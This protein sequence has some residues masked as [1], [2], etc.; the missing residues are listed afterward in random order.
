MQ[1]YD[2]LMNTVTLYRAPTTA[3]DVDAVGDWLDDRIDATV[4]VRDRF[5]ALYGDESLAETFASARVLDPYDRETGNTMLGIVR[6]EERAL[7]DPERGG[8]VIYDG[9]ALQRA[10]Y[11]RNSNTRWFPATPRHGRCWSRRSRASFS[12]PTTR[13]RPTH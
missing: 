4:R 3:A 9:V 10:L 8:G 2:R 5:C 13:G 1:L 7:E 12:S 11:E 6:Y